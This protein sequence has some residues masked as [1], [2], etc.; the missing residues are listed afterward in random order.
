L[1]AAS[2]TGGAGTGVFDFDGG[3]LQA[4]GASTAY[5]SGL[6][7]ANVQSGGAIVN[8]N[9]FAV[10][11][12]Q[13]LL[14]DT[15]SGA[16]ATDGGL[17]KT[18]AGSLTLSGSNTYTGSTTVSSGAL[19]VT[20][21]V[22]KTASA[23]VASGAALEVDGLLNSAATS[24]VG[25]A[26]RGQG[27][28]GA[29]NVQSGGTLAPG[30]SSFS[31]AAGVLTANGSLS[32]TDTSSIFSIRLGVATASDHDE[33]TM[34][35]GNVALNNA[36]LQLILGGAYAEQAA[37]TVDI[38][39]NGAPADSTITGEFA[40]GT[41]ITASNGNL[42]DI[43]Y[44]ENATDTGA[45][46]DVLLVAE[47]SGPEAVPRSELAKPTFMT[48]SVPEPGTWAMFAFGVAFLVALKRVNRARVRSSRRC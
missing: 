39:I 15:T 7:T 42:F 30:L 34:D 29:I 2:V 10:T 4:T 37:G 43:V 40:Q 1:T 26:L 46:H 13:Q 35:S 47:N 3:T 14:H 22:S 8:T 20:G 18:G 9:S 19:N 41:S 16:P 32:L 28:V 24:S 11:I 44:N 23:T 6:T 21:A 17:T 33:L 48:A 27:S 38:I 45:G 36:T 5:M 31:S 25:G 12:A